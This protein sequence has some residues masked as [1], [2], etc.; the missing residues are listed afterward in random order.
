MSGRKYYWIVLIIIILSSFSSCSYGTEDTRNTADNTA[1]IVENQENR[2]DTGSTDTGSTDSETGIAKNETISKIS[3]SGLYIIEMYGTNTDITAGGSYP[4]N[5]LR[6][7][8]QE[9]NSVIWSMDF[10]YYSADFI[11]SD[12]SRYV[13]VNGVARNY[14]ESFIVD[15]QEGTAITLPDYEM[16][17]SYCNDLVKLNGGYS[18]LYLSV[19]GWSDN[20]TVTVGFQGTQGTNTEGISGTFTYDITSGAIGNYQHEGG[21]FE[22]NATESGTVKQMEPIIW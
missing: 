4:Y 3:S 18:D 7:L 6:L 13:A 16:L 11:W 21:Y 20:N 1:D 15:A 9:D 8:N 19:S 12:N 14:S 10:G 2:I 17:S 22:K 5:A